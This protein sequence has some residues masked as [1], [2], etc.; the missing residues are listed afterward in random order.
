MPKG[1]ML[2]QFWAGHAAE[3][4]AAA[5][6]AIGQRSAN[7]RW[8]IGGG[9]QVGHIG[10]SSRGIHQERQQSVRMTVMTALSPSSR[11]NGQILTAC[12]FL[13]CCCARRGRGRAV[14]VGGNFTRQAV[15]RHGKGRRLSSSYWAD[16]V[17]P[18]RRLQPRTWPIKKT[19][20]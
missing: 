18:T 19:Q 8:L 5:R 20:R 10:R 1:N 2:R 4:A 14:V 3:T 11:D 15:R 6:P 7:Q 9:G 13:R 17:G 12:C 16:R